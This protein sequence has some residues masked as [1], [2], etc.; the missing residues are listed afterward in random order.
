ME[1]FKEFEGKT[2]DDAISEA[3]R[4]LGEDRDKLE[5]EIISDSKGGIFGL[6]GSRKAQV[7]ARLRSA[8]PS[9]T[10]DKKTKKRAPA[11]ESEKPAQAPATSGLP[12]GA[13]NDAPSET[14]LDAENAQ[15]DQPEYAQED[16]PEYAQEDQPEYAQ[17]DQ[18]EPVEV[19]QEVKDLVAEVVERLVTPIIGEPSLRI[20]VDDTGRVNVTVEDTDNSG[21]LIG[22]EGQTLSSLQYLANRIAARTAGESVRVQLDVGDYREK[23]DESL[24]ELAIDL[25][26]K[27]KAQGRPYSTR[28]LSS[29]HRRVVHLTLQDDEGINTRSKGEGAMKRVLILPKNAKR[30]A[31][32]SGGQPR[33]QSDR[34]PDGQKPRRSR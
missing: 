29:Y 2:I 4:R 3:C 7:R 14:L 24:R 8:E 32:P 28:P 25:A 15:E 10:V 26:A 17:E 12:P 5:I 34:R 18:P 1:D 27:A 13:V 19:T 31:K 20:E 11:T 6:M 22:R 30:N 16:Q 9:S 33:R 21:L 23:Q